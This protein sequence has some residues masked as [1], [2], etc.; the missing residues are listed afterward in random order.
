MYILYILY[1]YYP[2]SSICISI[3]EK[4]LNKFNLSQVSG[5]HVTRGV[6]QNRFYNWALFSTFLNSPC[7]WNNLVHEDL[8]LHQLIFLAH[9]A[10][11]D[12]AKKKFW[13]ILITMVF[14]T[15]SCCYTMLH[16]MV[17]FLS[18]FQW[19][20]PSWYQ[21]TPFIGFG[22]EWI[23]LLFCDCLTFTSFSIL[24]SVRHPVS[25]SAMPQ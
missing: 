16:L 19:P 13:L 1:V 17:H 9:S 7:M 18:R 6:V 24:S 15:S 21:S 14:P 5:D 2:C 23:K 22:W 11:L 8:L 20:D 4:L 10:H 25:W 12:D 3:L